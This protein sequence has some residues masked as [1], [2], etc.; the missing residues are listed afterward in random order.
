MLSLVRD[1]IDTRVNRPFC[2]SFASRAQASLCA[3]VQ[4]ANRSTPAGKIR[5][6]LLMSSPPVRLDGCQEFSHILRG[7]SQGAKEFERLIR[8]YPEMNADNARNSD[9]DLVI[10][11]P[12]YDRSRLV[13]FDL[14]D[15]RTSSGSFVIATFSIKS[16]A[17][18]ISEILAPPPSIPESSL[19]KKGGIDFATGRRQ[20]FDEIAVIVAATSDRVG[21]PA[22][23]RS[24][25]VYRRNARTRHP[26]SMCGAAN[27]FNEG[28]GHGMIIPGLCV[29]EITA[30]D[31]REPSANL[32]SRGSRSPRAVLA[33]QA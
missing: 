14:L 17:T 12:N 3:V 24:R 11:L 19:G 31:N 29:A 21:E 27:K 10:D 8:R 16:L 5:L 33:G 22:E 15:T 2:W 30:R 23:T 9:G 4:R 1:L 28:F 26:G 13:D 20:D 7:H 32:S 25:N 6:H 18:S